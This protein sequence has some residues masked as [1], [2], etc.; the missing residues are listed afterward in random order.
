MFDESLEA[1]GDSPD[2]VGVVVTLFCCPFDIITALN[3][4]PFGV[5]II[6]PVAPTPCT[7][8]F[9]CMTNRTRDGAVQPLPVASPA[10]HLAV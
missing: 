1:I 5:S 2:V 4:S 8:P 6:V 9:G 3:P 10:L 7:T